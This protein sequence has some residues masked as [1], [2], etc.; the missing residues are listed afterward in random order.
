MHD[1]KFKPTAGQFDASASR[2]TYTARAMGWLCPITGATAPPIHL[3]TTYARDENYEKPDERGYIRDENPAFDQAEAL[4][5]HLE[6]GADA[7]LFASGIAACVAP[8]QI[9]PAMSHVIVQKHIY[10]GLPL[11]IKD[12]L[13]ISQ[14][15]TC[16]FV[17]NGDEA[18]IQAAIDRKTPQLIWIETPSN[19]NLSV[20]DIEK[21]AKM[22]KKVGAILCVDSTVASPVHCQPLTLG[23]DLVFHSATKILNGHSDV[24]AG[25]IVTSENSDFWQRLREHRHLTGPF[26]GSLESY[27]L[28]R[29]MR[30]LFLRAR[31]QAQSA[32][33]IAEYFENHP[34]IETVL[35]PG[36]KSHPNH[37][38][39]VRQMHD[40][41]G[42][43]I[44]FI[45]KDDKNKILEFLSHL[46]LIKR[47]TSLG[48][49]ESLIE[50]R[51]T[52]EGDDSSTNERLLRFSVG[53][54]STGDIIND[55]EN[56][57]DKI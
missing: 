33:Q 21:V 39:A 11:W 6:Q 34:K 1:S 15:I 18:A 25:F 54:E 42:C 19:P 50:H 52:V 17:E 24:L 16:D 28:V 10:F 53:I 2:E 13:S 35:Y 41:F 38:V 55:I 12:Y 37:Q 43:L 48:G 51:K 23:A 26:L 47:A 27:L 44:S 46:K 32:L 9:L 5:C 22:A 57:L 45:M 7:M 40:G 14:A 30:T 36:L 20:T 29:G 4:I 49:I 8:F 3:S 56:A 31:Y